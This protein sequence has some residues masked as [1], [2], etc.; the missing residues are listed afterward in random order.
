MDLNYDDVRFTTYLI[1]FCYNVTIS[2]QFSSTEL[3]FSR[4]FMLSD[5]PNIYFQIP[6]TDYRLC[7]VFTNKDRETRVNLNSNVPLKPEV[8]KDPCPQ[9]PWNSKECKDSSQW[10][11]NFCMHRNSIVLLGEFSFCVYIVR[12]PVGWKIRLFLK[13]W[14]HC[15]ILSVVEHID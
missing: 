1:D 9:Y 13:V 5:F 11:T 8:Y 6:N 4:F 7:T 15:L 10:K 12:K 2:G 3:L 14:F